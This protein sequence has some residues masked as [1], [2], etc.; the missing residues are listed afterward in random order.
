L[1]LGSYINRPLFVFVFEI[2]VKDF[3]ELAEETTM[4]V[5]VYFLIGDQLF[6]VHELLLESCE[7]F[8]KSIWRDQIFNLLVFVL[9]NAL[10]TFNFSFLCF[11]KHLVF[12]Q[13]HYTLGILN[14]HLLL[15]Q[16]NFLKSFI[17]NHINLLL[18]IIGNIWNLLILS[19]KNL[20]EFNHNT[21]HQ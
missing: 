1:G 15:F 20:I 5:L 7:V 11:V 12:C 2:D 19:F 14:I 3:G 4:M 13:I 17:L 16:F 6:D 8:F 21:F 18:I 10:E 9:D